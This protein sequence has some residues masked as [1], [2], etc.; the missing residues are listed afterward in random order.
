MALVISRRIRETFMVGDEV[1]ITI[2]GIKDNQVRLA[3]EAPKDVTILRK[4]LWDRQQ[5]E[6][7]EA[8]NG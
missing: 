2:L 7:Q 1:S 8:E 3:I 6:K 4:E 5:A